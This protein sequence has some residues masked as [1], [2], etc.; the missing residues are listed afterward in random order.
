MI[1]GDMAP[2]KL[3]VLKM[4][5]SD[6]KKRIATAKEESVTAAGVGKVRAARMIHRQGLGTGVEQKKSSM[7]SNVSV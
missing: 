6:R 4:N 3:T 7:G 1:S 5:I 2:F